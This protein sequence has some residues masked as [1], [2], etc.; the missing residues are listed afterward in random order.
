LVKE[1]AKNKKHQFTVL[2]SHQS[3]QPRESKVFGATVIRCGPTIPY[4]G[5][6]NILKRFQV[7]YSLYKE[8]KNINTY[9]NTYAN[10]PLPSIVEGA[11][12][13]TYPSAY[14]LGKKFKAKKVATWHE[15]W[16]GEWIKNKGLVTGLFGEAWE[17]FSLHLKW[18][19]VIS[20]SD[21]TKKRLVERWISENKIRILHNGIALAE[22]KS[23]SAQKE[24]VPTICY[25][26]RLNWQKNVDVLIKAFA[27]VKKEIPEVQGKILGSGPALEELQKLTK[28]L[29]LEKSLK[30]YGHIPNYKELLTEVKKCHLFVQPSSL[31]GFGITVIEALALG[32]PGVLSDIP[33][34][35]EITKNGKGVEISPQK[36]HLELAKRII[37]LLKDKE[38]YSKKIQE[39]EELV[40][41]YD[42]KNIAEQGYT[43]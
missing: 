13:L 29:E 11:S 33:P 2:C 12:F 3:G 21:F 28:E 16:V 35:L 39:G 18:D 41:E 10:I 19:E 8:G 24:S 23:I 40:K 5:K 14:F 4:S 30:F 26:G 9:A 38:L 31:E 32:L 15:T 25:F 17:R 20:V 22:I 43:L 7:A 37:L 1:L 34:F 36:N 42:W 27:E 6:G